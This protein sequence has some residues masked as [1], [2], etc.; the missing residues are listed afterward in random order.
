MPKDKQMPRDRKNVWGSADG[1]TDG[2]KGAYGGID[3]WM[4]NV[5]WVHFLKD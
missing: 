3:G 4:V 5:G 2:E 1:W